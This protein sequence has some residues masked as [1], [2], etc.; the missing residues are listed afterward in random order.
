LV[1]LSQNLNTCILLSSLVNNLI[2]FL[3]Q[4]KELYTL[5]SENYVE[6]DDCLFRFDY[7][8]DFLKWYTQLYTKFCI[9]YLYLISVFLDY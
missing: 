7:Q 8:A 4:L 3:V 2:H 9:A 6:D 1:G 5:L